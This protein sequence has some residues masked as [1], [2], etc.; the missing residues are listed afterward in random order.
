MRRIETVKLNGSI[1]GIRYLSDR[2]HQYLM[3][4]DSGDPNSNISLIFSHPIIEEINIAATNTC[5]FMDASTDDLTLMI[6]ANFVFL[7]SFSTKWL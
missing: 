4:S 3:T 5:I 6:L 7:I 2:A 1:T